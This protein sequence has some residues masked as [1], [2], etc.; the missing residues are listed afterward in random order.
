MTYSSSGFPD[1]LGF[2][3]VRCCAV[4]V[5]LSALER[6]VSGVA[7][8]RFVALPRQANDEVRQVSFLALLSFL[9]KQL[10]SEKKEEEEEERE[11]RRERENIET[12]ERVVFATI[13]HTI[14]LFVSLCSLPLG[15]GRANPN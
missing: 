4:R 3:R 15:R 13:Q 10:P 1:I 6:E 9:L 2:P 7:V 5:C 12:R 11:R 8:G 14:L